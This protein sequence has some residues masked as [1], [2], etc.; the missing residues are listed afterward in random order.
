MSHGTRPYN[1]F[2]SL[3]PFKTHNRNQTL[4]LNLSA[5]M[6][7]RRSLELPAIRPVGIRDASEI[8]NPPSRN[9]LLFHACRRREA[10]RHFPPISE[11]SHALSLPPLYFLENH[12]KLAPPSHS[13][14]PLHS[15]ST[16][17]ITQLSK[18]RPSPTDKIHF[19][20]LLHSASS[21]E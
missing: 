7:I 12:P 11:S 6:R 16:K 1:N 19:R 21:I 8:L 14:I 20:C 9:S 17:H 3:L 2:N 5:P 13:H 4:A 18:Y 15:F 10:P